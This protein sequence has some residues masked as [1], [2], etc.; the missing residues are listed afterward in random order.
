MGGKAGIVKPECRSHFDTPIDTSGNLAKVSVMREQKISKTNLAN[1]A[2]PF[3][4]AQIAP[5]QIHFSRKMQS[6]R[7]CKL[8]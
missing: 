5:K 7:A 6:C 3:N 4:G 1:L 2:V 8:I